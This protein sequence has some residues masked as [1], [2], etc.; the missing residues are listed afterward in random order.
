MPSQCCVELHYG[1]VFGDEFWPSFLR[2]S[3]FSQLHSA[4]GPFPA[5]S[6]ETF[7]TKKIYGVALNDTRYRKSMRKLVNSGYCFSRSLIVY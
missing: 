1:K 6:Y 4:I 2:N 7:F 5:Y 3:F